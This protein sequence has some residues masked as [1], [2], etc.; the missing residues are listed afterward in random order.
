[1]LGAASG[2]GEGRLSCSIEILGSKMI[3]VGVLV[4]EGLLRD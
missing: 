2:D 4:R 1:M 3:I